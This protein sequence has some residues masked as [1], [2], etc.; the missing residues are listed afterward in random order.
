MSKEEIVNSKNSF[1]EALQ[2]DTDQNKI[3][4]EQVYEETVREFIK[5]HKV[6]SEDDTIQILGHYGNQELVHIMAEVV[7]HAVMNTDFTDLAST[8]DHNAIDTLKN[9]D[10]LL[11]PEQY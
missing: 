1:K 8:R 5:G 9:I 3:M 10:Q 2:K 6:L 7:K 4:Y 11:E